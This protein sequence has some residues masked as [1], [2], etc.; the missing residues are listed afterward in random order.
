MVKGKLIGNHGIISINRKHKVVWV[1]EI[2]ECSTNPFLQ[3]R[4]GDSLLTLT[5]YVHESLKL[6]IIPT[7]NCRIRCSRVMPHRHGRLSSMALSL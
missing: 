7:G 5:A 4:C 2:L 1:S 3:D 6:V